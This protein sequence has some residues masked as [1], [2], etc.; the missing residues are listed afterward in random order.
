MALLE[1]QDLHV[2]F[3]QKAGV[4]QAVRGVSFSMSRHGESLGIVGESGSGKSVSSLA[5]MRLIQEPPGKIQ[6]GRLTFDGIDILSL[7][8]KQQRAIR[9]A[10]ISMIFQEPM[11][12]LDPVFT[13]GSQLTETIT[14]HQNVGTRRAHIQAAEL[15]E[16]V[17]IKEP[18]HTLKSYP[19]QLSGGMRQ[20]VMIAM[21]L[22]CRPKI[23]IADEPTTALDVTVQAQ[24]LQIIKDMQEEIG[25]SLMMITHDLGVIAETV[26]NVVVMYGG[27]ILEYGTVFEIFENPQQ[28]YTE[29][30]L[31]SIPDPSQPRSKKLYSIEGYSPNPISPPSG[32]P[33]HPRCEFARDICRQQMPPATQITDSHVAH[34][35]RL[36]DYRSDA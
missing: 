27:K 31:Q 34:C 17:D 5:I 15:L 13:I 21:A 36:H 19:H 33:F 14:L 11:T 9:G 2:S 7:S 16:R 4:V 8:K 1:V 18:E 28:P 3:N 32:C 22:S 24:V 6:A 25:T 35:W 20:R 26:D 23:L 30:L 12:S 10:Q 29:A